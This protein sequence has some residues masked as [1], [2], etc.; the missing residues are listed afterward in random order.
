M[1]ICSRLILFKAAQASF[2]ERSLL[3]H[4]CASF[5]L[6]QQFV[7]VLSVSENG[8][9]YESLVVL[10]AHMKQMSNI[11]NSNPNSQALAESRAVE[12][13]VFAGCDASLSKIQL[14]L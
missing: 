13:E 4:Q 11:A 3:S 6:V 10:F 1:E 9:G 7:V 12:Y 5:M 2:L 8:F 14:A